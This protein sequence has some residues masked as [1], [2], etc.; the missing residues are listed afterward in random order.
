MINIL[1]LE[2]KQKLLVEKKKKLTIIFGIVFSVGLICL[3][4]ILLSIKFY[5]LAET[6]YQKNIL[7]QEQ[8]EYQ[9]ADF[10]NL[11]NAIKRYNLILTQLDSFYK[12]EIYFNQA[13]EI[14]TNIKRPDGLYL[15]NFSL[16]RDVNGIIKTNISGISDTRDNL[17]IFKKNI[18]EDKNIK[19]PSFSN[20]SWI[21]PKDVKFSLTFEIRSTN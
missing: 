13:L 1:P 10:I 21:S 20:E 18:I 17:L 8:E 5:I 3:I 2:E 16:D 12:N 19:N 15:K 14:I 6:D 7:M 4:L 9:T 11:N